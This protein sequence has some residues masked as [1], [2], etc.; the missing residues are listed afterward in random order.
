[1]DHDE[2]ADR[3]RGQTPAVLEGERLLALRVLEADVEH[4]AEV[5]AQ[6]V[7]RPSLQGQWS[8]PSDCPHLNAAS[9]DGDV[10]LDGRREV[11]A[12]ELLALRLAPLHHGDGHQV[13][14]DAGVQ[15]EDLEHLLLRLAPTGERRVAL[16][17]QEFPGP[18]ERRRMLELPALQSTGHTVA[19]GSGTDHDIAPLVQTD[20]QIAMRLNPFGEARVHDRL[21]RRTN[22]NRLGQLRLPGS[23]HPGH[24]KGYRTMG[25][26]R[27]SLLEQNQRY[28]FSHVPTPPG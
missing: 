14:V 6:V 3:P 20:G 23:C 19:Y 21:A 26:R 9:I 18:Q 1:M 8:R 17:P 24:L 16:L 22:G 11:A 28:A 5:L 25:T 15:L 7:T 12:G 10:G 2:G 27:K 13:R 4:L